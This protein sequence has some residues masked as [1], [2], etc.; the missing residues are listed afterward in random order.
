[1]LQ[2]RTLLFTILLP[3]LLFVLIPLFYFQLGGNGSRAGTL[4]V[5]S[6]QGLTLHEYTQGLVD[7]MFSNIYI[8]L[9]TIVP[10]TFAAYSIIDREE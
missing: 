1:M 5:P 6:L 8:L 2:Q 3:P 7:T 4:H 9:L 10:R